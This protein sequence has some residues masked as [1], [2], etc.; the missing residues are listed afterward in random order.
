MCVCVCVC[1][2]YPRE[3]SSFCLGNKTFPH[4]F[5]ISILHVLI[6][7]S[8]FKSYDINFIGQFAHV[9]IVFHSDL[10]NKLVF[11]HEVVYFTFSHK[12]MTFP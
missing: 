1:V 8:V 6:I 10:F 4:V 5:I 9:C 12:Q 11:D 7:T 3:W 2:C